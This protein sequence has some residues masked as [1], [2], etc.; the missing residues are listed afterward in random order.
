MNNP[1]LLPWLA[2]LALLASV[3]AQRT[4]ALWS[5][6]DTNSIS[7][8]IGN[9]EYTLVGPVASQFFTGSDSDPA[10]TGNYGLSLSSF[11]DQASGAKSA[12]VQFALSTVGYQDIRLTFDLRGSATAARNT[13]VQYSVNGAD[14]VDAASLVITRDGSFIPGLS[15]DLTFLA[16]A[17]NNPN[18]AFRIV[19]DFY[20]AAGYKAVRDGSTYSTSG[21][22]RLDVVTVSGQPTG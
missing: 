11:P 22:W 2:A 16:A 3:Q 1:R 7:P 6:N 14:F 5:F 17:N 21:T 15:V 18:F 8:A 10:A 13:M 4:V 20:D 12:G 19:S 9:G